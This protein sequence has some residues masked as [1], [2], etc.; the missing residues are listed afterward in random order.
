MVSKIEL[1]IFEQTVLAIGNETWD[2]NQFPVFSPKREMLKL[3]IR[4]CT[5]RHYWQTCRLVGSYLLNF[6]KNTCFRKKCRRRMR[7]DFFV[8][9]R[10]IWASAGRMI[11]KIINAPQ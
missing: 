2:N 7:M 4:L 1:R 6:M 11:A 5:K 9:E 3:C 10:F 8:F